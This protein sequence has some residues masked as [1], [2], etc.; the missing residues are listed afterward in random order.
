MP[1]QSAATTLTLVAG[2]SA[3]AAALASLLVPGVL[4]GPAVMQG[5]LRGTALVLLVVG[6]PVLVA[7]LVRARAGSAVG[8]LAWA[9]AL[10]YLTYQGVMFCFATPMNPLFGVYLL[11]LGSSGWALGATVPVLLRTF[12]DLDVPRAPYRLVGGFLAT[13]VTLNG[14]LWLVRAVPASLSS[15]PVAFLVG[16]GLPTNPVWVQDL[17]VWIPA[18]VVAGIWSWRRSSAGLGLAGSMLVFYTV[19]GV[20]VA[21][22]QWWGAHADARWPDLASTSAVPVM[23][24]LAGLTAAPALL[25][26]AR[27][28]SRLDVPG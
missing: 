3:A 1:G 13:V 12:D 4:S 8:V 28:R 14:V 21:V 25:L 11:A 20:S 24:V 15:E 9:G 19:E 16:S 2:A 6:V 22:D 5:N 17:T 7:G 18:G 10:M 23:L 26:A 27:L